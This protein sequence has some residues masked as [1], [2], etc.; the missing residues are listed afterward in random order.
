MPQRDAG[1]AKDWPYRNQ[2][3]QPK[4]AKELLSDYDPED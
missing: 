3:L 2:E 1:N 4:A